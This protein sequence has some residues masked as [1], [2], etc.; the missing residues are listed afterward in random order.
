VEDN[1]AA[2]N[3]EAKISRGMLKGV[4]IRKQNLE[5]RLKTEYDIENRKM[6]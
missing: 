3:S 6:M 2:L 4:I 1:L 5:V